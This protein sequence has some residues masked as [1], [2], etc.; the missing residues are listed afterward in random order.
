MKARLYAKTGIAPKNTFKGQAARVWEE[1]RDEP[2]LATAVNERIE[3]SDNPFKTRQDS[4]RV[5]LYYILVFK[6]QGLVAAHEQPETVEGVAAEQPGDVEAS[7]VESDIETVADATV[8]L[9]L[10]D[11][12]ESTE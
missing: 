8:E 3:K 7:E 2:E 1:L 6:K 12:L 10:A 4:Y 5:T 9:G 11:E